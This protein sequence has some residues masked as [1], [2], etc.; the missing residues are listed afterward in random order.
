MANVRIEGVAKQYAGRKILSGLSLELNDGECFTL[1]GPSGCGKTV[2]LRLIA[3][4]ETPDSGSIAIG[5]EV[6]ANAATGHMLPPDQ[7]GLGVV[8]QDYAVWPHMTVFDNVVYPLKLAGTAAKSLR[9]RTLARSTWSAQRSRCPA[10]V[11][12]FGWAA[13]ARGPGA[14]AGFAAAAPA[15][16]RAAHQPG[17]EPA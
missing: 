16:G 13:A 14:R 15:A 3:G 9:E 7:R 4:F 1:L 5:G 12:T 11:A 2:L 10:A 17:R 6:V 8:F